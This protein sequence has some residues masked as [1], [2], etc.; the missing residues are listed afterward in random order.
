MN[1]GKTASL[2]YTQSSDGRKLVNLVLSEA[3]MFI[4][5]RLCILQWVKLRLLG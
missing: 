3:L 1:L 5:A 2:G 4:A